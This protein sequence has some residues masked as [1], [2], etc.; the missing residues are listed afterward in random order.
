MEKNKITVDKLTYSILL[1]SSTK[2]LIKNTLSTKDS[3]YIFLFNF[4]SILYKKI[5]K[6]AL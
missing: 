2:R 5:N 3:V 1:V 6:I 4:T